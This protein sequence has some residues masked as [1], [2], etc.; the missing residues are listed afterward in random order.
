MS[1]VC[2]KNRCM[3]L[4]TWAGRNGVVRVTAYRW[5]HSGRL[6]VAAQRAGRLILVN[7]A[8]AETARHR[9]MA[10]TRGCRRQTNGTLV[11]RRPSL[12]S[13]VQDV[14]SINDLL[15]FATGAQFA[16]ESTG[17]VL[18]DDELATRTGLTS[19]EE[20]F[21][22]RG[23]RQIEGVTFPVCRTEYYINR[24]FAAVGRLLQRHTGPIFPLIEDLFGLSIVEVRQEIAAVLISPMLAEELSVD[25]GGPALEVRR[26]YTTSDGGAARRALLSLADDATGPWLVSSSDQ[27]CQ[28]T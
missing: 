14:V 4:A 23:F 15:A 24:A 27:R 28:A 17:M 12:D 3:N 25:V 9:R 21:A 19:G 22:V 26:T 20:W 8:A 6:P 11:M 1:V 13:Y 7:D 2:C 5:F 10:V 16:I 18:I